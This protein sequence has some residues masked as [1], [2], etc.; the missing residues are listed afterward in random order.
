M[1]DV[2]L[3]IVKKEEIP[4]CN[5]DHKYIDALVKIKSKTLALDFAL[6]L[7]IERSMRTL[8]TIKYV[9]ELFGFPEAMV[10]CSFLNLVEI[11]FLSKVN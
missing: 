1:D 10:E 11:G 8:P 2:I 7:L 5:I 6:L 9:S 4:V 3:R